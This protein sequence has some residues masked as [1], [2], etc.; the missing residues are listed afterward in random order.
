M[1][2]KTHMKIKKV[3]TPIIGLVGL[4]LL[5]IPNVVTPYLCSV[6]QIFAIILLVTAYFL[7]PNKRG[8]R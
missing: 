7:W 3:L 5:I 2:F 6:K 8:D 4:G 1:R